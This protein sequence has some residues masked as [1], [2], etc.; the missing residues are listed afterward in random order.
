M[1]RLLYMEG[2]L[3]RGYERTFTARVVEAQADHVTL[4]QTLFYPLGGGQEWDT[5]TLAAGGRLLQVR[6]VTK[7]GP[8]RHVVG[9]G[10]G[11]AAGDAVAGSIDWERRHAHMRMHT[12][13]HLVSGLAYEMFGGMRTVGNQIHRSHSRIDFSPANFTN[14]MLADLQAA[15]NDAVKAAYPVTAGSMKREEVSAELPPERTNLDLLPKSVTDLRVIRIG[16]D[17]DLCPCAGT[18]VLNTK[19]IGELHILRR[20]AKGSGTQRVEY[21]LEG[22]EAAAP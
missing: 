3:E 22:L 14:A 2:G 16:A 7:R 20:T 8:V 13:Q 5:G 1:T 17:V 15:A 10:H 12:A 4:D 9:P 21:T 19:E 6:E 18:H 11:L